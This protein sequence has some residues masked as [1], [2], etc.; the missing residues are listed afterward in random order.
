MFFIPP[1]SPELNPQEYV[2]QDFKTNI[3]GNKRAISKEQLKEN[4]KGFIKK[5]K[6]DKPQL[7]KYLHRKHARYAT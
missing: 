3:I 4:I 7:I 5:R 2:N 6:K 1:Y